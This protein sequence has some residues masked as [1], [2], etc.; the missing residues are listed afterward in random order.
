MA[1]RPDIDRDLG[2]HDA[3]ISQLKDDMSTLKD[4]VHDIKIMMSEARGGWKVIMMI[5]GLSATVGALVAKFMPW[6]TK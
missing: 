5:A 6:L 4:D 2:K 1:D 3:E